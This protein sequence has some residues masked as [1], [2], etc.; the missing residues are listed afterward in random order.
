MLKRCLAFVLLAA[1]CFG[2]TR[3]VQTN[4]TVTWRDAEDEIVLYLDVSSDASSALISMLNEP[5]TFQQVADFLVKNTGGKIPFFEGALISAAIT[6]RRVDLQ[7][8]MEKKRSQD[9]I[10]LEI[11]GFKENPVK[12]VKG[13]LDFSKA[14]KYLVDFDAR[15]HPDVVGRLIDLMNGNAYVVEVQ[16]RVSEQ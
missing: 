15:Q 8:E 5:V 1:M 7:S 3:E 14:P 13:A 2:C 4:S 12:I 6:A 11:I 10:T 9:G 16:G